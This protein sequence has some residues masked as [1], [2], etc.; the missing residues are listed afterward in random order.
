MQ[1]I[2]NHN[3]QKAHQRNARTSKKSEMTIRR[4]YLPTLIFRYGKRRAWYQQQPTTNSRQTTKRERVNNRRS[5]L[6]ESDL[7]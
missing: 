3:C 2:T 6:R 7:Y 5:I 1:L 4:F